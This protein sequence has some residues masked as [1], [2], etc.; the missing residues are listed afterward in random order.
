M[1]SPFPYNH[2]RGK[3]LID[4]PQSA[5]KDVRLKRYIASTK[6]DGNRIFITK[7]KGA[8]RCF[9]SDWK[10]FE[11]PYIGSTN[12]L[13]PLLDNSED[14]V[15]EA[16]FN[17]T[18]E[19]K[20]GHRRQSA[21]LTTFRTQFKKG[22]K[23]IDN[24]AKDKMF[25]QVFDCLIIKNDILG[26]QVPY[27]TRLENAIMLLKPDFIRV[28]SYI[29]VSGEVIETMTKS[30][31]SKGWEGCMFVEST[32]YYSVGKRVNYVIKNK[33]RPTADLL[34]IGT[35]A[36]EV[37]SKYEGMIGSLLLQ[38]ST[39]RQVLVGS[40]L[41]DDYRHLSPGFFIG[42]VVEIHYE[43]IMDTYIQP[44]FSDIREFK[45]RRDID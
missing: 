27:E 8:I 37:G 13:E 18:N 15:L 44:T 11:L 1:P 42:K 33:L 45:H 40:G 35:E 19:G 24:R 22:C 5:A 31:V 2:M 17:Y 29:F 25:I 12:I 9:T 3:M 43:Q 30:Q 28:I 21:I 16:E 41:S 36:G 4:L 14:F 23:V 20:L 10:E 7:Y 39:G 32:S 38:D 34:C 26:T 6:Y